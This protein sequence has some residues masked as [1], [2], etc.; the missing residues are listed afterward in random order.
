M[1]HLIQ[2]LVF[3]AMSL[4]SCNAYSTPATFNIDKDLLLLHFDLKTDV[5]DVHTV[6]ALHSILQ[7]K[8]FSKLNYFAVSGTYGVQSGLYV[9]ADDLFNLVF[10]KQWTDAH[11]YRAV[12]IINTLSKIKPIIAK[13]GRV[14]ISEAGQ[15]DFT[16]TLLLT[17]RK[18]NINYSKEQF[19]VVQHSDWNEKETSAEALQYVKAHT[20]YVKL[21]DGNQEN[22]G[23]PGFNTDKLL[24]KTLENNTLAAG[25]IW[26][27]A[28]RVSFKYNGING[29]YNNKTISSGGVDFSDLVEVIYALNINEIA[30]AHQFFNQF[31]MEQ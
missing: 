14:W 5:D 24:I 28:N 10:N 30:N 4:F 1:K 11:N 21:P 31:S 29:R 17:L 7:S 23:S 8:R 20:T 27:E 15:S 22:N 16:Q 3:L 9:P 12:A 6:A 19:I 18:N 2:K 13:G 26:H 25:N